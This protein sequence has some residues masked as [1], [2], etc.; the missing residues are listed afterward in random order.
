MLNRLLLTEA[1]EKQIYPFSSLGARRGFL[2]TR[3]VD[4][5]SL[6]AKIAVNNPHLHVLKY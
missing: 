2:V 1:T 3:Q 4:V 5:Y 6:F